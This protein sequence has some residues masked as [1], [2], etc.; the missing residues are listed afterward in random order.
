MYGASRARPWLWQCTSALLL[1][2]Q[3]QQLTGCEKEGEAEAV[4][5]Q[6]PLVEQVERGI[7]PASSGGRQ[8]GELGGVAVTATAAAPT[9]TAGAAV[10][11]EAA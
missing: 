6:R 5:P 10:S 2:H 3:P 7:E 1:L 11:T 9:P 4:H 8:L